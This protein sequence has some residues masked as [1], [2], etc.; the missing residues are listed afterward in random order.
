MKKPNTDQAFLSFLSGCNEIANDCVNK[1]IIFLKAI[2][3]LSSPKTS[4]FKT[5]SCPSGRNMRFYSFF[6]SL[7]T[8]HVNGFPCLQLC[9]LLMA[10]F[11]I[12]LFSCWKRNDGENFFISDRDFLANRFFPK[13]TF[14]TIFFRESFL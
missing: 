9:W 11:L 13:K 2:L 12:S 8:L 4:S 6:F 10:A 1:L 3:L 14:L 5:G 7:L